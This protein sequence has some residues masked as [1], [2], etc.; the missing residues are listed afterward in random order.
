[1]SKG[2]RRFIKVIYYIFTFF[3]GALLAVLLPN[4][5]AYEISM[6]TITKSLNSGNYSDAMIIVG[7]YIDKEYVY[8]ETFADGGGIVLFNAA[9][10]TYYPDS[11]SQ[12]DGTKLHK[13][14]AGFIYGISKKYDVITNDNNESKILITRS[15]DTE[16]KFEFLDYDSDGDKVLDSSSTL[17]KKDFIYLDFDE[18]TAQSIKEIKFIDKTGNTSITINVNLDYS[19]AFFNDVNDFIE[20][21]NRDYNSSALDGLNSA[22]LAKNSNYAM[23]NT[24]GAGN[25]AVRRSIII[26]I[27]YFI[28]IYIIADLALGKRYIIKF[29][30]FILVKV[31]KVKFKEKAPK[32]DEK[33][34]EELTSKSFG[35]DFYSMV[36]VTLDTTEAQELNSG[37]EVSYTRDGDK[38]SFSLSKDGNYTATR[39]IKAGLYVNPWINMDTKFEAVNMPLKLIVDTY[40]IDI[41]IKIINKKRSEDA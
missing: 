21:Y 23:S 36:T 39:R 33:R 24:G 26:V 9:T 32:D 34:I 4:W 16:A 15:D 22:F 27:A 7:G 14:Y 3:L 37:V 40:K 35:G 6:N 20:E 18:E 19:N 10:L 31:F 2:I 11:E 17:Y 28:V 12:K 30:K 25:I 41:L 29:F 38:I 13:A 5:F 1:M 8:Q